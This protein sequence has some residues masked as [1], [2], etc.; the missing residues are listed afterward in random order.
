[1][2]WL[3]S[4]IKQHEELESPVSFWYWSAIAALSAVVKDQ[5]WLNRQIYNL[6]PNIYVMLHAE[7]GLKK[8]PPISMARQ[9]VKPVN[10]TRII[11]GRS[12][13]QG[14]LKDL[15]T[16]YT[17]P[18]GKIQTKSVAFICSSELSSS[19]VEDKVATKILTDLYDRQ[20]NVGEWRSLLK[21]ETFELK[22]PTITMLTATNEAMSEDFFTRSAI[23]GGYFARTF[24]I[25]E[26]ES[27]VSN[28]LIYPLSN[29]PNYAT[30]AD[31]LKQVAKLQGQF[32]PIAQVEKDDEF[33]YR[34]V[35]HGRDIYFNET[36]VIYDDWYENFKELVKASERDETG[37]LNRFGDSVLKVA[38]LLS[39]AQEPT[40]FLKREAMIE[41]ITESEKLLGNVRK[42]TMGRHGISQSSLLKTM[43]IMELLNRE[44][45]QITR[46][47][48]MK[49]MWQH[50]ENSV[51]FD[52]IMQSFDAS[53]MIMTNNVGNQILYTM[54]PNQ[55]EELKVYMAGKSK[56]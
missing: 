36:G 52:D 4:I 8:G 27:K 46:T 47:V 23:Q 37:T 41:A 38:M 20:Y 7:S 31:Y 43:I 9:L 29:P 21:M 50:Y 51:E 14:I 5:V 34:K 25:Y 22:D 24:I 33:R 56:K 28:S 26:K 11:S 3:Q 30:S 1:M 15:G 13:I 49:K 44:N 16:A 35:K 42:T 55:V 18:G 32:H 53:G 19:I 10:N 2:S 6:Y 17:Q 39:L 40:L 45:H 12:S 54:P 48:L